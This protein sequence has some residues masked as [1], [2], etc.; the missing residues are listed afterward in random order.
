MSIRLTPEELQGHI[1]GYDGF[2][3]SCEQWTVGGV[4][5][6][7]D[8]YHCDLCGEDAVMGAEEAMLTENIELTDEEE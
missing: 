2:C 3:L 8:Q 4:E 1:D 6:D 5:P 7:A